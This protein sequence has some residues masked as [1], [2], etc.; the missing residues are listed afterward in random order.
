MSRVTK[1]AAALFVISI[2]ATSLQVLPPH[3]AAP[4]STTTEALLVGRLGYEGGAFPGGFHPTAGSVIVA[5]ANPPIVLDKQVGPTGR[6]R[7]PLSPGT[8][9][10][11]GCGPSSS[12]GTGLCGKSKT[13]TLSAGQ[14][15]HIRLVWALVP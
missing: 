1:T 4:A 6:F 10:V 11:T 14:V 7:I 5:F 15:D 2:A 3:A 8:Y 12:G 9:I 13:V